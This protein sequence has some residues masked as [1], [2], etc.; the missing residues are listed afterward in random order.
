M[1]SVLLMKLGS[2]MSDWRAKYQLRHPVMSEELMRINEGSRCDALVRSASLD[3][4]YYE[5]R[6]APPEIYTKEQLSPFTCTCNDELRQTCEYGF[7][8]DED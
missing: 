3:K 5:C 4:D 7:T 8:A 2:T 6:M 1:G